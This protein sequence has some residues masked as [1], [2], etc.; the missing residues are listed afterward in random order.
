LADLVSEEDL[1]KGSLYPPLNTIQKCSLKI[2]ARIAEYA[3][4]QGALHE[5]SCVDM[6]AGS[7]AR[8][9]LKYNFIKFLLHWQ[10]YGLI[11]SIWCV[12][13][14]PECRLNISN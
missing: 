8:P 12:K 4:K 13:K 2:A 9:L 10:W 3:Y 11:T 6:V 5:T 14:N 1:E 7:H